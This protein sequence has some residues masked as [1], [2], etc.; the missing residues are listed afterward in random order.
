MWLRR[1]LIALAILAVI[2]AGAYWYLVM[3]AGGTPA[4]TFGIDMAKVRALA[5]TGGG[6]RE[7]RVERIESGTFP[8]TAVVAGDGWSPTPMTMFSYEIVTPN[9]APIVLDTGMPAAAAK[10]G[11]MTFN[12]AAFARMSHAL[13]DASMIVLTHEH[14]DHLGGF[15]AQP[16]AHALLAKARFNKEQVANAAKYNDGMKADAF[17]GYKPIDYGQYLALAPGV[18][19]IRAAGHTPGSQM[20]YVRLANGAEYLF[21]GDVA[22]HMRNIDTMRERARLVSAFMLHEDRGAVLSQLAAL[23]ALKAAEP[24]LHIV[25][26]HDPGPVDALEQQGLLTEGFR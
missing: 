21:T 12:A 15:L 4:G 25:T 1:V 2:G 7:I 23:H 5:G 14:E 16:N 10:A 13:N 3:D 9:A 19:L 6:P 24:K 17:A 11:G 18:V 8:S 20:V 22:W 26:G